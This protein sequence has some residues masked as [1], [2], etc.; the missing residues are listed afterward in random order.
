MASAFST[1][2]VSDS[3]KKVMAELGFET[4]TPI[5]EQSLEPLLAGRDLVG[6]SKTGSGK[7]LAF[8]LPIL[9][10]IQLD[11]KQVQALVMCPTR[12]LCTQV[13]REIRKF[14]RSHV[15]LQVLV[16]SGGTP[17]K[18]QA[19]ALWKGVHIVVGTPGRILDHLKR[20]HLQ[21]GSIQTL[22]LDEADRMLDMG[23]EDDM[24]VILDA[25][26]KERQSVFFSATYPPSI[27]RMSR[28]YQDNPVQV[29]IVDEEKS[30]QSTEHVM[31]PVYQDNKANSLLRILQQYKP[32][33]AI[34]FCNLKTTVAELSGTLVK[35]GVSSDSLSGDLDQFER[36]RVMAKFRNGSVQILVATDVAAR[37]LDV[38]NLGAVIN[39][40]VP[41]KAEEYV[42]RTGRTGRAG[43]SGLAISLVTGSEKSII[44]EIESYTRL[45]I[46]SKSMDALATLEVATLGT[47]IAPQKSMRTLRIGG[48][49]KQKVRP[50]DVLG[51]LT[52]EAGGLEAVHVGKIEIHD[53]FSYVGVSSHLAQD[54]VEKLRKGQ[55]KGRK[56]AVEL[57]Q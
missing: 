33:S 47:K 12:E 49:R 26:P 44:Q 37:G 57:L 42:H 2:A 32:E 28:R 9:Q 41:F 17:G 56:F 22:V 54:I 25:M 43:K 20:G 36:D 7:T 46:F 53:N 30:S 6:Q 8:S 40:D 34:V 52:G 10:S 11:M 18:P 16:I 39:F 13:A 5:Q 27:E 31:F 3:L 21:T 55:I 45:K 29:K 24:Q 15:G 48:G 51:A 23:F 4:P 35:A 19:E 50:G 38:E 14:G 1:L